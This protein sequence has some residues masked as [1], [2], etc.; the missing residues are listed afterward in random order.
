[1]LRLVSLLAKQR[2]DSFWL[3][4]D[5]APFAIRAVITVCR[6]DLVGLTTICSGV[7]GHFNGSFNGQDATELRSAS[8]DG[9]SAGI[10][11]SVVMSTEIDFPRLPA[12]AAIYGAPTRLV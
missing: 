11:C 4:I 8:K 5:C 3:H 2:S 6:I 9:T 7:G 1:M 10:F 12:P